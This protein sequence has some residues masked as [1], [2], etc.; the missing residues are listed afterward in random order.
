MDGVERILR[1]A[2]LLLLQVRRA[3]ERP[4]QVPELLLVQVVERGPERTDLP[5]RQV[6]DTAADLGI[7]VGLRAEADTLAVSVAD[8]TAVRVVRDPARSSVR[9]E[10][11]CLA[12][13]V[14]DDLLA[15]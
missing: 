5:H 1:S 2:G 10:P 8:G 11:V 7:G 13:A 9:A 15:G 4:R 14:G 12:V 6:R 3:V